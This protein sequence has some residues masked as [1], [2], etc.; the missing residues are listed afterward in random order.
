[1]FGPVFG[2]ICRDKK[3]VLD[4]DR[5]NTPQ[6]RKVGSRSYIKGTGYERQ[7]K[8]RG[9]EAEEMLLDYRS[10][11]FLPKPDFPMRAGLPKMEQALLDRWAEMGLWGK[12]RKT[13]LGRPK[14]ILHDG[15]PYANGH[16]HIGTALNKI[17]KDIVNRYRQSIGYD[18]DYVPGWDCHG[19]PIE[20]KIEERRRAKGETKDS[21]S[22][23][24]FRSECREFAQ[25]WL[26]IQREEFKRL[27]V[28]GDWDQP[29][30][31]MH[32]ESEALIAE[33]L[34]HFL[35]NGLLYRGARP[36]HW[37]V[38]EQTALAEAELEY[39]EH[40]SKTIFVG[41]K[42][43]AV[44]G[45]SSR[46]NPQVRPGQVVPIWT[47]TS[48]TIPANRAVACHRDL[49]YRLVR[50]I[51][52]REGSGS[53]KLDD[54]IWL[55]PRQQGV[56][57]D[58][59]GVS[60][61]EVLAEVK[62]SELE[63]CVLAH[64][65][66]QLPGCE[67]FAYDVPLLQGDFVQ[68]D[69]GTGFVHLAPGHG[70]DDF[71]LCRAHGIEA[72]ETVNAE[73]RYVDELPL[74][75]GKNVLEEDGREGPANESVIAALAECGAL[76]GRD[77]LVHPYPHSWRSKAPVIIRLASQWFIAMDKP[78]ET[79]SEA[80]GFPSLAVGVVGKTLRQLAL[81]AIEETAF[82][83][84][85]GLDR[86]HSMIAAR[87]DWCISRQRLWGVPLP[88]FTD[89]TTGD[90]LQDPAVLARIVEAFRTEGADAW[91][92]SPKERFLG[93]HDP[94]CF[95]QSTD[96]VDV[97]FDSGSTHA[98]VLEAHSRLH[99]PADLYLEG[100][101][102]HRG[103]FHSSLLESCGTR[104]RAP[105]KGVLTHGFVND[106]QGR[107]MSKSLGNTVL[108]SDVVRE[109]GA[110]IIRL[111]V[112]SED[113]FNDVGIGPDTLRHVSDHY[114]RIRN[115]FRWLIGAL[116]DFT[117]D[118]DVIIGDGTSLPPLE[119]WVLGRLVQLDQRLRTQ[120]DVHQY[121]RI[122]RD[123]YEFCVQDLSALYFDVRKDLVYCGARQSASRQ[124]ALAVMS[125]LFDWLTAA[126]AP[127]LSFTTEEA[128]LARHG[129]AATT[130]DVP[131]ES[132]VDSVH[133]QLLPEINPAW[134]DEGLAIH[135]ESVLRVRRA[136]LAA[137]DVARNEKLLG[138]SLE[139]SPVCHA[140]AQVMDAI[141]SIS[142]LDMAELCIT[143]AFT[144]VERAGSGGNDETQSGDLQIDVQRVTGAKCDR[145]WQYRDDIGQTGAF[146]DA[147]GRCVDAMRAN[148]L[149]EAPKAPKV[150]KA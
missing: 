50:V 115:S 123:L 131:A 14:Y 147:C 149:Q 72:K 62:G 129:L 109:L 95:E 38:V 46:P 87:P 20:W 68:D 7:M 43:A 41:F 104:G 99:S 83:P 128:F 93:D 2:L 42:I 138:A 135:F 78:L 31:T 126:W 108:P 49:S 47:T 81:R 48:W 111:W 66:A 121:H 141:Q 4:V 97:W 92:Q 90:A 40:T 136:T 1:M 9:V 10:T 148:G 105:Y 73:G 76:L 91:Y 110:D 17:L 133:L 77:T 144:F 140:P 28:V 24:E 102:Q 56:A 122:F 59:M 58:A 25:E 82:F 114:R 61:S 21:V 37:S 100:T 19:L 60:E 15:P 12:I 88:I 33:E 45:G 113:Y 127:I 74:F 120:I 101:D 52:L 86:L 39:R 119:R 34:G 112:V 35:L 79:P 75:G 11:I 6:G 96:V 94:K 36:V 143:S 69:Q 130:E 3:L 124:Q 65:L 27:G 85:R 22:V 8:D 80:S 55:T 23:L 30:S 132:A 139:A 63:G 89:K 117:G 106:D 98:F 44:R 26:D 67:F 137:I 150:R 32:F 84:S 51:A 125:K 145:C 64:P 70:Q 146:P 71:R 53:A 107:K 142:G 13:S 18:A 16:L 57:L 5:A 118:A 134:Q 103:W 29:Y 116:D 54:E